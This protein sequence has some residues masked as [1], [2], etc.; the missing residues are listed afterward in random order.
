MVVEIVTEYV[1]GILPRLELR[2]LV[3]HGESNP[4]CHPVA[5]KTL[6]QRK[7]IRHTLIPILILR[8]PGRGG[9]RLRGTVSVISDLSAFP[10]SCHYEGEQRGRA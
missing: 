3:T 8:G 4:T 9:V 2:R 5:A 7:Y 10:S 6:G 1:I